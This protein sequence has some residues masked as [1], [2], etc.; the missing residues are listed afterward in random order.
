VREYTVVILNQFNIKKIKLPKI[1]LKKLAKKNMW[2]ITIAIYSV[3]KKKKYKAK[4]L[5]SLILT[6]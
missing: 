1:I 4:F 2:G 3:L 5:T 6:K